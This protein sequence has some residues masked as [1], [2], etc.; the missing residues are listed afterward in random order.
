ME[1]MTE[2]RVIG[3]IVKVYDVCTPREVLIGGL[4]KPNAEA[5]CHHLNVAGDPA[6][7]YRGAYFVRSRIQVR[8]VEGEWKPIEPVTPEEF[9]P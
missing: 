7:Y 4:P 3:E 9:T 1:L 6:S 8:A 2:S 5:Y